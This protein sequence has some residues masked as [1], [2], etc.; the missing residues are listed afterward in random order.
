MNIPECPLEIS[1]IAFPPC[2]L[3]CTI[4]ACHLRSVF[5]VNY[6]NACHHTPYTLILAVL[7]CKHCGFVVSGS[8][9][10]LL[11][12]FH[13]RTCVLVCLVTLQPSEPH[14]TSYLKLVKHFTSDEVNNAIYPVWTYAY[15]GLMLLTVPCLAV[16]YTHSRR[17][18]SSSMPPGSRSQ[19]CRLDTGKLLWFVIVLGSLGRVIT[20]FLLLYGT[21]LFTMQFMQV[22]YA[23]GS[24]TETLF[25]AY[26]FDVTPATGEYTRRTTITLVTH[27]CTYM[28]I[29]TG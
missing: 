29:V 5:I 3:R 28:Y 6:V 2:G 19:R 10:T 27:S 14:L 24:V 23:A 8:P 16:A 7:A 12:S 13:C 25:S 22:T 18:S 20:R 4:S 17:V 9:V 26:V 15:C 11:A 1:L 21:S